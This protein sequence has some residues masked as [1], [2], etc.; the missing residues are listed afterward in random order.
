MV[1]W[2]TAERRLALFV[3][4]RPPSASWTSNVFLG[5]LFLLEG[6]AGYRVVVTC[7]NTA[8]APCGA[9][10]SAMAA[11]SEDEACSPCKQYREQRARDSSRAADRQSRQ[12]TK[13]FAEA[14]F[15]L[16]LLFL[17]QAPRGFGTISSIKQTNAPRSSSTAPS[18]TVT[19]K[20]Y[21]I[22]LI[23]YAW[24]VKNCCG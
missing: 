19:G 21:G 1:W 4:S 15:L 20:S 2:P 7:R 24:L 5:Q 18:I 13:P 16:A 23:L 3:H 9:P 17:E 6:I 10:R 11:Q 12:A 22:R 8:R 14:W